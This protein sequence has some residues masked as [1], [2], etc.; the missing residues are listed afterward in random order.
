MSGV[1]RI[2][3]YFDN[4]RISATWGRTV[5]GLM[6]HA[7]GIVR[8]MRGRFGYELDNLEW[9]SAL[10]R[11]K[12]FEKEND[13][14]KKKS[15]SKFRLCKVISERYS[16]DVVLQIFLESNPSEQNCLA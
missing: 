9:N 7:A 10:I 3:D 5:A 14:L 15:I 12:N 8:R 13:F 6:G 1:L 4:G 2:V 11:P 16:T